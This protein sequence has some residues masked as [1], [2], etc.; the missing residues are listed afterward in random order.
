[1]EISTE[2]YILFKGIW[3]YKLS[4]SYLKE[5]LKWYISFL[6][7]YSVS[8]LVFE[9]NRLILIKS[10]AHSAILDIHSICIRHK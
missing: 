9:I 10:S 7:N 1:M 5:H 6:Y 8:C 4:L 2:N 3:Q